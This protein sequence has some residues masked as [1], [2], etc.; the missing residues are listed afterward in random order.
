VIAESLLSGVKGIGGSGKVDPKS[1]EVV[2]FYSDCSPVM[3]ELGIVHIPCA[4]FDGNHL[5][6]RQLRILLNCAV[7]RLLG[8]L[9]PASRLAVVLGKSLRTSCTTVCRDRCVSHILSE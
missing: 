5:H 1:H 3:K 9:G 2:S 7:V 8:P 4:P 6:F